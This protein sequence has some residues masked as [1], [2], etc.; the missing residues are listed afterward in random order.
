MIALHFCHVQ[1]KIRALSLYIY[2]VSKALI[3]E[4]QNNASIKIYKIRGR[5]KKKQEK[6]EERK[7][8]MIDKNE[9]RIKSN[10]A[11][12]RFNFFSFLVSFQERTCDTRVCALQ[13]SA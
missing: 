1:I 9:A 2:F 13:I 4:E 3:E 8:V 10:I 5:K 6:N 7:T 12:I 11:A